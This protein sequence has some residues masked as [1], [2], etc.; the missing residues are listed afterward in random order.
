[1]MC[2][3]A[4]MKRFAIVPESTLYM[5]D[6][7]EIGLQLL[8]MDLSL[9]PLGIKVMI[10]ILNIGDKDGVSLFMLWLIAWKMRKFK[11]GQNFL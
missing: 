10:P 9:S 4:L 8:M 6:K 7:S 11:L 1:M 2:G 5:T 3:R